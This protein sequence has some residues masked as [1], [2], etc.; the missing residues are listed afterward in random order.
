MTHVSVPDLV[1]VW[2]AAK[3]RCE[4]QEPM[5]EAVS[6]CI[7]SVLDAVG[8]RRGWTKHEKMIRHDDKGRTRLFSSAL[9]ESFG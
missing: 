6:S 1:D 2:P 9:H 7:G 5:V 8:E 3:V 4:M